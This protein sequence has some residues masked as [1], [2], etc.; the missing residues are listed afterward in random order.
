MEKVKKVLDRIF[1]EGL[2]AMAQG[3]FATLIIGTIIQQIGSFIPGQAGTI[4]FVIGKVAASLTG[5]GIGVAVAYKF[6]ESPLVVVSAATAGMTG[7][8]A[9]KLL[10]GTVLVDGAMVYSGPG[11]PLGA[12]LAAYV[13]IYFG[14][15]VSGKTKVD[16][17]VTPI[18][19]IGTG[20]AV[21]LILGPPI[22]GFMVWLGSVIN[23][24]T[25]AIFDGNHCFCTDGNDTDIA[26][27]FGGTGNYFEFIRSG[28]RSGDDRL[29]L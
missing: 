4:L 25:E 14:H 6:N 15:L 18:I 27:Q 21:G 5:A 7:A 17:L 29:L 16:I 13:G 3:L 19:S 26:D 10:A 20:S 24:G 8:F 9:S 23:W 1:I 22:S 12:F 2:S 28:S 11:E